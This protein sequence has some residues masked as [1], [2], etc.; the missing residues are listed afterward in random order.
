MDF[1][2]FVACQRFDESSYAAMYRQGMETVELAD[3]AGFRTVWFPEHHLINFIACPSPLLFVVKAAERTRHCRVGTAIVTVPYYHPLRLAGDIALADH[4]TEGRLE[5][6][7]ARGA[8]EYELNRFGITSES[9]AA[10]RFREGMDVLH[11]LFTQDDF[12]YQGTT[13]SFEKSTVVPKPLQKP[14]PPIWVAARSPETIRY[15]LARGYNLMG[16]AQQ[17]PFARV[18]KVIQG[19]RRFID[20]VKPPRS[21]QIGFSRMLFVAPT[22]GEALDAV[23]PVLNNHRIFLG[24]YRNEMPL[25]R[26]FTVPYP[27]EP[28]EDELTPK[29][30]LDNIIAG[31]P[32]T[33]VEKLRKYERLGIDQMILQASLGSDHAATMK[34]L[35]LFAERVMPHF[36]TADAPR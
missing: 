36:R 28:L 6:G 23:Q 25:Q 3:E 22:D 32:D 26:G 24:L 19:Y 17:E 33:C 14:H 31:S 21:P 1:G 27:P 18:E 5:V 30:L 34:S 20:E 13:W 9:M 11:G 16:S 4:L 15:A 35:R 10:A 2:L 8:Y 12:S 7:V 29:E